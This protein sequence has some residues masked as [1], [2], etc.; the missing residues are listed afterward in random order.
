M[1]TNLALDDALIEEAPATPKLDG[2]WTL[3]TPILTARLSIEC[4]ELRDADTMFQYRS[5]PLISRFQ[6]WEPS[7]MEEMRPMPLLRLCSLYLPL[8]F[9]K[10]SLI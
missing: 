9:I 3:E 4:P 1:A 6:N 7:S 8:A 2:L 5:D 10:P